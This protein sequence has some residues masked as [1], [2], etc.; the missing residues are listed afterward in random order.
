MNL[1][2]QLENTFDKTFIKFVIIGF[3]YN[4]WVMWI[5]EPFLFLGNFI[6]LDAFFTHVVNW[7]FWRKKNPDSKKSA[8]L[9]D[10]LDVIVFA[11]VAAIFIRIFMVEAYTIPSPSMEKTLL[12]GD[13]I[14]VSKM[15]YGPKLPNTPLSFPFTHHTM[16]LLNT[17]SYIPEPQ[18]PYKRLKGFRKIKHGDVV[19]FNYPEGDSVST[20]FQ[21]EVSYYQL[22]RLFGREEV[23]SNKQEYGEIIYRPVDKRENFIKRCIG[24]PGDTVHIK[25][26]IIYVNH[27]KEK[28][29]EGLQ[30][31]YLIKTDGSE[32]P[33]QNLSDLD[34]SL[35][36]EYYNPTT[37]TYN[38]PLTLDQAAQIKKLDQIKGFRKSENRDAA[39]SNST[40]FPHHKNFLWTEDHFGPL[41]IPKKGDVVTI[42]KGNMPL[43]RRIITVFEGNDLQ[44]IDDQVFINGVPT[45]TY[46][47]NMNYYFMVGDNRHNST[48]SRY[49]GFVPENHI[50]GKAFFIWLSIDHEKS[51]SK[52]I[53]WNRVFRKI[54]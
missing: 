8:L 1:R 7:T 15:H 26:S 19:V 9:N 27:K 52:K 47:F 33:G 14:F 40:I 48:D 43:Y 45:A 30:F 41:Y 10:W 28:I 51:G 11:I 5:E 50:V 13:Y 37:R 18:L 21:S 34:I 35:K 16:P 32:I 36:T 4:I 38:I 3:F 12:T 23:R 49:W 39:F 29:P 42:N 17:K 54:N 6:I 20:V 2:N 25:N 22:C 46:Q 44:M 53:R 24:L 31:N